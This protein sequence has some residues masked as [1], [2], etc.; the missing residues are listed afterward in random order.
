MCDD[1]VRV[2]K[3]EVTEVELGGPSMELR[4]RVLV[5]ADAEEEYYLD[6]ISCALILAGE[7]WRYQ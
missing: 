7:R 2:V 5:G 3:L 6:E 4:L 1:P